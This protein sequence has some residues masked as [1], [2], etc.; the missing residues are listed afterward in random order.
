M[1]KACE[2][3]SS[4]GESAVVLVPRDHRWPLS[5][6][7]RLWVIFLT[8]LIDFQGLTMISN[9]WRL[10]SLGVFVHW[11]VVGNYSH[12]ENWIVLFFSFLAVLK[13]PKAV[14]NW[15]SFHPNYE[16]I[17]PGGAAVTWFP[18]SPKLSFGD[19]WSISQGTTNSATWFRSWESCN[20]LCFSRRNVSWGLKFF[21]V[22]VLLCRSGPSLGLE[23]VVCGAQGSFPPAFPRT[24]LLIFF[25]FPFYQSGLT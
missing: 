18:L 15:M 10:C 7:H 16:K 3:T 8:E 1:H 21:H 13:A 22:N 25:V 17:L 11:A 14:P 4:V 2:W 23:G 9:F 20:C 12:S 6:M 24:A 5:S 19:W